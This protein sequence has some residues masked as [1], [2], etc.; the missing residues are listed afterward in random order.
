MGQHAR[1]MSESKV[2]ICGDGAIGKTCLISTL[3]LMEGQ[4]DWGNPEYKPTAGATNACTLDSLDGNFEVEIKMWDTAGQEALK[5]LRKGA[6][7]N[8][9]CLLLGFDMASEVSLKNIPGWM[10]EFRDEDGANN[11]A[12]IV[13]L[14]GTKSDLYQIFKEEGK[15]VPSIKQMFD[16]A[17]QVGA[18]RMCLTSA[19]TGDGVMHADYALLGEDEQPCYPDTFGA[20]ENLRLSEYPYEDGSYL[21]EAICECFQK[22]DQ[23][24]EIQTVADYADANG[25]S[26]GEKVEAVALAEGEDGGETFDYEAAAVAGQIKKSN[27][28]ESAASGAEAP[29]PAK[30]PEEKKPEEKKPEE[31]KKPAGKDEESTGC[32]SMM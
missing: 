12:P 1:A 11:E 31:K 32:C 17:C 24:E 10:D 9:E 4:V 22:L 27:K 28:A 26:V 8:T 3:C 29:A 21:R 6:Y 30:K 15:P 5:A 7:P 16:I 13:I 2:L 25:I 23:N 20:E 18:H 14:V 19:K